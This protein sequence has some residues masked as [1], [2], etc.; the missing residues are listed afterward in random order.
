MIW[1][2]EGQKVKKGKSRKVEQGLIIDGSRVLRKIVFLFLVF[3]GVFIPVPSSL[4]TRMPRGLHADSTRI[5][6]GRLLRGI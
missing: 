3:Q 6:L 5:R 4:A 1:V 2:W